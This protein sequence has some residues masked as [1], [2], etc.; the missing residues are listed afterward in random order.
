MTEAAVG[1]VLYRKCWQCIYETELDHEPCDGNA[2]DIEDV[3][4]WELH[5]K[6]WQWCQ[7]L[8]AIPIEMPESG[9]IQTRQGY[10]RRFPQFVRPRYDCACWCQRPE[11]Y[12]SDYK[13]P[14]VEAIAKAVSEQDQ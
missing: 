5:I 2:T 4:A 9:T 10:L 7:S 13:D 1:C 6:T 14:F 3:E 8:G 11:L 12:Q